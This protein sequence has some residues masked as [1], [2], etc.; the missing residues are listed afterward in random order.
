[1]PPFLVGRIR[2]DNWLVAQFIGGKDSVAIDCT[3]VVLAVHL[4]HMHVIISTS[5]SAS[6]LFKKKAH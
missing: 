2:W 5:A 1:M 3:K 4:N 6:Y